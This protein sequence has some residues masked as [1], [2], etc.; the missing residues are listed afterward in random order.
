MLARRALQQ[1]PKASF[2][3]C[4]STTAPAKASV[5]TSEQAP[6]SGKQPKMKKFSIYR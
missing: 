3:R 2:A 5:A 6:S 4:I 1:L